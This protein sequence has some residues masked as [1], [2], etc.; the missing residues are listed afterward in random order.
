MIVTIE[1]LR[2]QFAAFNKLCFGSALV[3]PKLRVGSARKMLGN[4]RYKR[5]KTFL[6]GTRYKDIT[7]SISNFYDLPREELDDVILH[8]MIHL[9]IICTHKKDSSTHGA[10]FREIM[11]DI[12]QRYGRHVSISHRGR[13][14]QSP[15]KKVQRIVAI[16]QLKDGRYCVTRPSTT[17]IFYTNQALLR[18]NEV[19]HVAWF[20]TSNTYFDTFPRSIR[21]KLYR[22]DW[23]ILE[24]ELADAIPV[25]VNSKKIE[26]L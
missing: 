8:E 24:R 20:A 11:R 13:L 3:E 16:T 1:Y 25:K 5:E 22:T 9:Y 6:G 19:R 10:L 21:L 7:L 26:R 17:R 18:L 4:V 23:D 15:R 12:N 14:A 2:E